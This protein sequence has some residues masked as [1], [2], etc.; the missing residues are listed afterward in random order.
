M[1]VLVFSELASFVRKIL[2]GE[3]NKG[4]E[5]TV[6]REKRLEGRGISPTRSER[7]G[8][9]AAA[10]FWLTIA[11]TSVLLMRRRMTDVWLP[12]T[13]IPAAYAAKEDCD[14]IPYPYD[15]SIS[16]RQRTR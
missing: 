16:P 2:Q 15:R 8:N 14:D 7:K 4:V 12:M 10:E 3:E 13:I 5:L 11:T 9:V 6:G 1:L